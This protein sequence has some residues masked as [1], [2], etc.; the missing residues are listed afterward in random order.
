MAGKVPT[1]GELKLLAY[2]LGKTAPADLTLKLFIN[3]ITPV[4][5][6]VVGDFTEMSTLGYALKTLTM[7]TWGAAS[8][9]GARASIAYPQ[10]TWTFTAGA[11]VTVYG[12]YIVDSANV[13]VFAEAFGAGKVVQFTGDVI[14]VTPT[15]TLNTEF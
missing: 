11:A 2:M 8:T 10:Q 12:Y 9:I 6:N 13:V 7:A 3:N 5:G 14:R 4:D 15:I 1:A